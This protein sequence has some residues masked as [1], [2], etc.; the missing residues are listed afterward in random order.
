MR[1]RI[2]SLS[3]TIW[4]LL[5]VLV[6]TMAGI[7][8]G[9]QTPIHNLS[10]TN[11]VFGSNEIAIVSHPNRTNGTRRVTVDILLSNVFNGSITL[12][13]L[14]G[15]PWF[16]N[17]HIDMIEDAQ[18]DGQIL[19]FTGGFPQWITGTG[20]G[21]GTN[22]G[23]QYYF[24]VSQFSTNSIGIVWIRDGALLTNIINWGTHDVTGIATNRSDV[25]IAGNVLVNGL[26]TFNG[27][28]V[29]GGFS[30]N[31]PIASFLQGLSVSGGI[32]DP[33]GGVS[34][35]VVSTATTDNTLA[36]GD[37]FGF[38]DIGAAEWN[39]TTLSQLR[40]YV[41]NGITFG[42]GGGLSDGD[43]G[44]V[45]VSGSGSTWTVDSGVI[46]FAKMQNLVTKRVIGRNTASTGAP[47][48]VTGS[49]ILDWLGGTHGMMLVRDGV[50]WTNVGTGTAGQLLTAGGAGTVPSWTTVGTLT[51]GDKGDITLSGGATIYT[52]DTSTVTSNHMVA[53]SVNNSRILDGTITG[54]KLAPGIWSTNS[55][56]TNAPVAYSRNLQNARNEF[57]DDFDG[58]D[59][60]AVDFRLRR[61]PS[62][63]TYRLHAIDPQGTNG[64]KMTGGRLVQTN[65]LDTPFYLS[66]SNTAPSTIKPWNRFGAVVVWK[67]NA[68]PTSYLGEVGLLVAGASDAFAGP[69]FLHTYIDM[70][71]SPVVQRS[72]SE[73]ILVENNG[74]GALGAGGVN[75]SGRRVVYEIN[76][77]TNSVIIQVGGWYGTA[78]YTNMAGIG[79]GAVPIWELFGSGT[80]EVQPE[81]ES[82]WAGYA[83][84]ALE[85][86]ANGPRKIGTNGT[87]F[88]SVTRG[89]L[90]A[91][92][93]GAAG[94][95]YTNRAEDSIIAIGPGLSVAGTARTNKLYHHNNTFGKTVLI[96]D[97]SGSAAGSNI[98]IQTMDGALIRPGNSTSTNIAE[99]FGSMEL[100]RTT[101][102]WN[103]IAGPR[104]SSGNV[105]QFDSSGL[106]DIISG[107]ALSNIVNW[108]TY[109]V[110]GGQS[111]R[112]TIGVAGAAFFNDTVTMNGAPNTL[113]AA[114][115][116]N[117]NRTRITNDFLSMGNS[118]LGGAVITNTIRVLGTNLAFPTGTNLIA[119][120]SI[121]SYFTHAIHGRTAGITN[122]VFTNILDGQ[123]IVLDLFAT[124]GT[125]VQLC[126]A[127]A[128]QIP[129]AWY[130]DGVAIQV[131][132]NGFSRVFVSRYGN[133]TNVTVWTPSFG[134]LSGAGLTDSTNF[135]TRIITQ[136]SY[137]NVNTN[138][139]TA[140]NV[141]N[142]TGRTKSLVF[143][144]DA[145]GTLSMHVNRSGL[146]R[147][148][149]VDAAAMISNTTAGATFSTEELFGTMV[150]SN[151]MV[152]QYVFSGS[153]SNSVQFKLAMPLEWDLSTIKVKLWTWSTNSATLQTN[154][155]GIQAMAIKDG[156][157]LTNTTWGTEQNIT[158][159]VSS[160]GGN[161]KLSNPCPA[162]TVG[163]T[164]AAAGNL[165]WFRVRRLP[166]NVDDS[167][168]GQQR[169]LGAWIQYKEREGAEEA[170]W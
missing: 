28:T 38:V 168:L 14:S 12:G 72:L 68:P 51:D 136:S 130:H 123:T 16:T 103:V 6:L 154:I 101:N 134:F 165:V 151:K 91:A 79:R 92:D 15:I 41:T 140:Y 46:N 58:P 20:G 149:Y 33:A 170:S 112:S 53:S 4:G 107:A 27:V 115:I 110:T 1:T 166:G 128:V 145:T 141:T 133:W 61:S 106:L 117:A 97:E 47:E 169:L 22:G 77:F 21:G 132:T 45:V 139:G 76:V 143:S 167:D 63:H 3:F 146:Y 88:T 135:A 74:L 60:N 10:F 64:F 100:V 126:T 90:V 56:E 39:K 5:V 42:G 113:N 94:G 30:V 148:I 57:W 87:E 40:N 95:T 114:G 73:N 11:R 98:V 83:D 86:L 158:N 2:L 153:A 78:Y 138:S 48:E 66:V 162:L 34:S 93:G 69:D 157:S 82:I 8:Q 144:N 102:G 129:D 147:T 37:F 59:M 99:N 25:G 131:N 122:I 50:Q 109:E 67:S 29:G 81:F 85:M 9:Q 160:S 35:N 127:P 7:A 150:T 124:N 84:P 75:S 164:P 161:A 65:L 18:I 62:G 49:Q 54:S 105:N 96:F 26:S 159:V 55:F 156:T 32:L 163:N 152:D 118:V 17:G 125:Q 44:D 121:A 80:N 104:S 108:G 23:T 89:T 137:L 71:G 13:S 36:D 24:P 155:F 43:K 19:S 111:N 120:G 116:L 70:N 142:I 119:D 31:N 52:L